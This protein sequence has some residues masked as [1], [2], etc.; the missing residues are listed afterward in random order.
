M[1]IVYGEVQKIPGDAGGRKAVEERIMKLATAVV[2]VPEL[3]GDLWKSTPYTR[4]GTISVWVNK[5]AG[6]LTALCVSLWLS[7]A[8]RK[9]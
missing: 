2:T 7:T 8:P 9:L 1:Q 6:T 5:G 3:V 4:L